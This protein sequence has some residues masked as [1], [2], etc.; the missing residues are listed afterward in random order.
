M[1]QTTSRV[2]HLFVLLL[3]LAVYAGGLVPSGLS[4]QKAKSAQSATR[5]PAAQSASK[6]KSNDPAPVAQDLSAGDDFHVRTLAPEPPGKI[7]FASDRAGNFDIY[8]M[9]PDGSG[10]VRLTNDPA[11]DTH[12]TWSPDGRQIA[13]V[14]NRDGNKEIYVINADGGGLTRLTNNTAEDFSPAWSPATTPQKI[15]FVSH[16]DGNDEVYL[17]NT[18]GSSQ[19]NL[20]LNNSDDDDPTWAPS[21]TMLAFATNRDGDKFEIY[22]VNT[23]M[24]FLTRITN[25]S[26]NDVAPTWAPGRI[27]YQSDR[28]GNDEL[29]TSNAAD[30]TNATRITINPAFDLDPARSTDG[31]R[32]VFV[33]NRDAANNLELYSA[34]ADGSNTVRLTNDPASDIDP[35]IQPLPSSAT[36]GTVQLSASTYTVGEGQGGVDITVTRT[37][38]SGTASVDIT[39]FNGTASDRS[40]FTAI[41]RTLIFG[42]GETSKT[43]RIPVIDDLRI[44]GDETF[45]VTLSGPVNTTIGSPNTAVVTI[46]DNDGAVAATI[47]G[48]TAANNLVR[49]NSA[50][51]GTFEA[52]NAITGLQTGETILGIDVRPAT[53]QIYALGSTGRIYTINPF[54]GAAA[55]ASTASG[56]T[57]SGTSFGVDFNPVPDRLRVVSDADQN[58]RFNVDTGAA[59]VD[60][61]LAYATG[62]PNAGQNPNVVGVAYTNN[63]AGTTATTLYGIDS[64]RDTLVRQG[65][66]GGSP[67]SPNAGQLFTIGPLGVDTSDV[68]GFD[69]ANPSGI[70]FAA[71]TVGGTAQLYTINLTTGAATLVGNVGGSSALR[72]ITVA[73]PPANPIDDTP[74]F[75]RQQY[76]D[77][78]NREPDAGGFNAWVNL[79]NNCPNRL[80]DPS[81]DRIT[82]SAAFF[83]SPEF[84]QRGAFAM[85]FY[86]AAFGRLPTYRE[87]LRDMSALGG[88]TSAEALANRA[89]FPD[90]FVQRDAFHAIY[91]SLSNAAYV[92]RLIANAG[93]SLPNRNQLVADLDA[94]TKT[95]AQVLREVVDTTQF[96]QAA[97]NRTFVLAEY[98]GYL[99]RDPE[100][101]GFNAWLNYLNANPNDFR[102]MV[103][104]FVDSIEYR[105]RFGPP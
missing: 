12:P 79:L 4:Q 80:N 75:V 65:S 8:V 30:G 11:E 45:D 99:R 46:T 33:S 97:F 74:F 24:D 63:F 36:L 7:A 93:V 68:V 85:R 57:L 90:D 23:N 50:T 28:D 54:T 27:T 72:G 96:V 98:F 5:P 89:R 15:A 31:A 94:G 29:Y 17:M 3:A 56:A 81:C 73:N 39:T 59:T 60:T 92:D 19:T 66:V 76:L 25:N 41:S 2:K 49:F 100:P 70:A 9:N 51:P 105:A 104:G 14:S 6:T 44:E 35:A 67:V 77:F 91:D 26:A 1:R 32:I 103:R 16:R 87:F 101:A 53:R 84:Q 95:R 88:A 47:Y 83:G 21:G 62:D 10:L 64:A 18:D 71:L 13:F 82:V 78:L 52:T 37:G 40:D 58:L 42:A 34:N 48:V 38:G 69:I 102:T 43:V 61:T 22:R 20:T 55:L 86:I